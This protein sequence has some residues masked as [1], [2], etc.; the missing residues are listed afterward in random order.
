MVGENGNGGEYTGNES[1]NESSREIGKSEEFEKDVLVSPYKVAVINEKTKGVGG[2]GIIL[3]GKKKRK[4]KKKRGGGGEGNQ[5]ALLKSGI[6]TRMFLQKK[7]QDALLYKVLIK[8]SITGKCS[9]KFLAIGETT[10][11]KIKILSVYDNAGNKYAA[12][13]HRIM[14]VPLKKNNTL[15]L[16]LKVKG[17]IKVSLKLEGYGLQQ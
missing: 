11:D 10:T 17:A 7:E 12:S 16:N 5:D 13:G 1:Q 2:D 6:T 4:K 3:G 9:L 14:K 15:S 8:S